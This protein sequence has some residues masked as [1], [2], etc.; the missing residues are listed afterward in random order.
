MHVTLSLR[1]A[2]RRSVTLCVVYLGLG[3]NGRSSV[4]RLM[5]FVPAERHNRWTFTSDVLPPN[6]EIC[7]AAMHN[8]PIRPRS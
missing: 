4:V 3:C 5:I 7:C 6:P 2:A 1:E 8:A